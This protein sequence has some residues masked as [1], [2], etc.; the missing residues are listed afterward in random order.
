MKPGDMG[1]TLSWEELIKTLSYDPETGIFIKRALTKHQKERLAGTNSGSPYT[2]ICLNRNTYLAHRLAWY[3][4]TGKPPE[5]LIDHINGDKRDN[6]FC[7]LRPADYSQNMMNSKIASSNTSGCKGVCWK[8]SEKKWQAIGKIQGKKK[9]LGYF[10]N[11]DEAVSAYKE[12]AIEHHGEF[13]LET[14]YLK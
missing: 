13:Y 12:F 3:Y 10:D 2:R 6:R 9:H 7:N 5:M 4:M 14:S 1:K 11:F 8:K